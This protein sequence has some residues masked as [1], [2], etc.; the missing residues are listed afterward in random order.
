MGM[1]V[2]REN[3]QMRR[4]ESLDQEIE[5][6]LRK[7]GKTGRRTNERERTQ[8]SDFTKTSREKNFIG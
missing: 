5:S 7:A 8:E 4:E 2:P 6:S 3:V 1:R